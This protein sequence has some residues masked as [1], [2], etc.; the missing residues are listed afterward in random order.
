MPKLPSDYVKAP[1]FDNP[2]RATTGTVAV[3]DRK[4]VLRLDEA[5]WDA[6]WSACERDSL[7]PEAVIKR[8][9]ERWLAGDQT[10]VAM[11]NADGSRRHGLRAQ[12]L[13]QVQEHLIRIGWIKRLMA[14]RALIR[15]P[16]PRALACLL[17]RTRPWMRLGKVH[18]VRHWT[19]VDFGH[20]L[21]PGSVRHQAFGASR[22]RVAGDRTPRRSS[23]NPQRT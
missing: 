22:R 3:A 20:R 6:V 15:P 4:L 12:L 9:L 21:E 1:A 2:L 16:E 23:L 18:P 14:L 7:T 11:T 8:A 17:G 13:E 5:T 10:P 19:D